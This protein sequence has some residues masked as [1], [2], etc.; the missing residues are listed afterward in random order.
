MY[1]AYPTKASK[2]TGFSS[3]DGDSPMPAPSYFIATETSSP[4]SYNKLTDN[5]S[6]Y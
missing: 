2:E 1:T 4:R 5:T 6:N 3:P